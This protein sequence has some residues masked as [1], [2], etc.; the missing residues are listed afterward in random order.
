MTLADAF[1]DRLQRRSAMAAHLQVLS[2]L[3]SE[4]AHVT[5]FGVHFGHSTVALLHGLSNSRSTAMRRLVSYDIE[6]YS[7]DAPELPPG[8]EWKFNRADT[9]K[10]SALEATDLLLIDSLHT[11][12]HVQAELKHHSRVA[13]YIVLHDTIT[14]GSIGE[15]LQCPGLTHA[16]Y[17]FLAT[18]SYDWRVRY[19]NP[20]SHGL[21]VLERIGAHSRF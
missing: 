21:L 14:F 18:H 4:C 20:E 6:A 12:A 10:V 16:I 1:A 8:L 9:S 15:D 17:A 5:E 2:S 19:H 11:C 13:R 7:F 3:A